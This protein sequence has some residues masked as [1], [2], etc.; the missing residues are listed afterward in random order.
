TGAGTYQDYTAMVANVEAGETY[1]LSIK[2]DTQG[3]YYVN[4]KAWID[5]NNDGEFDTETEEYDLG[6]AENVS[7]GAPD[8]SPADIEIPADANGEY[9]LR[10]RG[11][12]GE[13]TI[14]DPCAPQNWSETEDYTINVAEG[15]E[16]GGPCDEKIIMECGETY[17]TTLVPAA[18]EWVNYTDVTWN[19][20]GSEQV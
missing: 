17:T 16:P 5:W 18:G 20:T 7:D 19:Y 1:P 6:Q 13:T 11:S 2:V 15:S 10:V 4:A 8:M 14:V 9:R 12:F 3:D